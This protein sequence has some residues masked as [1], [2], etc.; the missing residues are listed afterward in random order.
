MKNFKLILIFSI[1]LFPA[2][3]FAQQNQRFVG[4]W[5]GKLSVGAIQL[6]LGINLS[7]DNNGKINA[8]LDSP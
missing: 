8:L 7:V 3:I 5:M 2:L 1:I 4:P 6:R